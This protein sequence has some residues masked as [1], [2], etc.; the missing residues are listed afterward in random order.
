MK[1]FK[2]KTAVITGAGNGF[3]V[4]FAKE[5]ARRGMKL[6]LADIDGPGVESTLKTCKDMGAECIALTIDLSINENAKK[7]INIAA[8]TYGTIDLLINNAGVAVGGFVWE[9][10]VQDYEWSIGI[11]VMA[12][13]CAM[14]EAIPLML[15]QDSECHIVNVA[16]SAGFMTTAGTSVYH[17]TKH[18]SVAISECALFD[19]QAVGAKIGVSVYCPGFVQT[20]LHNYERHRPER[21]PMLH[22]LILLKP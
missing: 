4:E 11:N 19:L 10:P 2:G 7:M 17:L 3:G 18:A 16:S 5:S 20:D 12:Q 22:L 15:K 14:R 9:T 21:F 1:N 13:V 6:V 8:D